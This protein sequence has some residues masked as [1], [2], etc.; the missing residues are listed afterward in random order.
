MILVTSS[1]TKQSATLMAIVAG[2]AFSAITQAATVA[3]SEYSVWTKIDAEEEFTASSGVIS[4]EQ[5]MEFTPNKGGPIRA[6]ATAMNR[7]DNHAGDGTFRFFAGDITPSSTRPTGWHDQ[8]SATTGPFGG[9]DANVGALTNTET[10]AKVSAGSSTTFTIAFDLVAGETKQANFY[11]DYT[12]DIATS[13]QN[14][15]EVTW[16]LT[17]DGDV[18]WLGIS[19]LDSPKMDITRTE[20]SGL[21]SVMLDQ[22]GRYTLTVT[23]AIP[24][25]EFNNENKTASATLDAIYFEVVAVPEPSSTALL[26]L[27][28]SGSLFF[29]RR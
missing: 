26:A 7:E 15:A 22:A 17:W 8:L 16:D 13:N 11:L 21:E 3:T 27:A 18:N 25:Q 9:A 2:F 5:I 1:S 29:R 23:S 24:F 4:S 20:A 6:A 19:G 14:T 10:K 12:I 28:L